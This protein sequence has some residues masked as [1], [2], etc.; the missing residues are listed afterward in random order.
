MRLY[1]FL[2]FLFS[3]TATAQTV[4]KTPSGTKY[5]LASCRMVKNV[6]SSTSIEKAAASALSPCKICKPPFK[7][8]LGFMSSPK[9]AKV[10]N[11]LSQCKGRTKQGRRCSRK[12]RIGNDYCF[13]HIP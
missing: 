2:I 1:L 4:Y 5:H 11:G 8:K 12:T 3:V 10:V 6:S 13:Q 7:S 9:K